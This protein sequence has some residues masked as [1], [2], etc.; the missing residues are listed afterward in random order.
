M[1]SRLTNTSTPQAGFAYLKK[2]IQPF[3]KR[4]QHHIGSATGFTLM[5]SI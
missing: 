3:S 5:V 1:H 2:S 4:V